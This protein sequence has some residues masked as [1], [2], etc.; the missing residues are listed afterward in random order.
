MKQKEKPLRVEWW[1]QEILGPRDEDRNL[2]SFE[3]DEEQA[4]E[5]ANELNE[6]NGRA[7]FEPVRVEIYAVPKR[8]KK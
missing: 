8:G 1:V 4:N 3:Y 6:R 5:T 7:Q 2:W